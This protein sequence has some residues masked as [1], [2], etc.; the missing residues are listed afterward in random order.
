MFVGCVTSGTVSGL[1]VMDFATSVAAKED[2]IQTC[3]SWL[4][5]YP[6]PFNDQTTVLFG[7][8]VEGFVSLKVYDVLGRE[9]ASP[10][11]SWLGRGEHMINLFTG[12]FASGVYLIRLNAGLYFEARKVILQK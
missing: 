8:K 11:D 9:V 2:S 6:N 12:G 7:L 10:L 3:L 4:R 1:Y 5:N